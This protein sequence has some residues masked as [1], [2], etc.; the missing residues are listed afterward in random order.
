MRYLDELARHAAESCSG[1]VKEGPY[2]AR[3]FKGTKT[4]G[5]LD[6]QYGVESGCSE[7]V[8]PKESPSEPSYRRAVAVPYPVLVPIPGYELRDYHH[9]RH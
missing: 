4:P 5:T 6:Y 9:R 8:R 1:P 7:G 3:N 2:T